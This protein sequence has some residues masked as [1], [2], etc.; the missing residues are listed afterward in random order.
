MKKAYFKGIRWTK[1]FVTGPLDPAH[2]QY[3][4]Y[5]RICKSNASI[6]SKAAREIIR[7]YQSKISSEEGPP[8]IGI[9][10]HQ[11]RGKNVVTLTPLEL[12]KSPF[13]KLP[14]WWTS[15]ENCPSMRNMWLN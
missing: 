3:K 9:E 1:T 10:T 12:E 13:L 4:F 2:N 11:D 8:V 14:S 5:C 7:H 15:E 6:Y